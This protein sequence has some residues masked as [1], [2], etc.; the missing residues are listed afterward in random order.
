MKSHSMTTGLTLALCAGGVASAATGASEISAADFGKSVFAGT[1]YVNAKTGESVVLHKDMFT[2]RTGPERWANND[3]VNNGNFFLGIDSPTRST[4]SSIP[5]FG[6]EVLDTGD[7]AGQPGVGALVDGFQISI[8]SDI[9]GIG[10]DSRVPGLN[11]VIWFYDNDNSVT[12]NDTRAT[13]N[14]GLRLTNLPGTSGTANTWLLTY[15]LSGGNEIQLG[16]QDLDG[17]GKLDFGW[18]IAFQQNQT[19][20]PKG[21]IGPT[22]ALPGGYSYTNGTASTSTS[23]GVVN[24]WS[25]FAPLVF[26]SSGAA[27][28]GHQTQVGTANSAWSAG[29]APGG[30]GF[31]PFVSTKIVLY[32]AETCNADFNG[33]GFIDFT[34]FDDF[35]FAFEGGDPSADFNQDGFLDFTDF[36]AFVTAFEAGC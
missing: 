8:A 34:D 25:I 17:D 21:T 26:N 31:Q 28:A 22:L 11:A 10:T 33:D 12:N 20:R 19:A 30:A 5:R 27:L 1:M 35:V 4:T 23:S 15:D 36:D 14:A 32:G 24:G 6:A 29:V 3:S 18:S 7:I 13:P 2:G 16:D 9:Q